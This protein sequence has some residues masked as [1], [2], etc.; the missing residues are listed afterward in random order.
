MQDQRIQRPFA[1]ATDDRQWIHVDPD[2]RAGPFGGC[3]AHGYLT[4]GLANKFLPQL[5]LPTG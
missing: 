4:L 1:D 2:R 5:G 3:V